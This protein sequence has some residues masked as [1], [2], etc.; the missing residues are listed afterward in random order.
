MSTNTC[1]N[2]NHNNRMFNIK[3]FIYLEIM[4]LYLFKSFEF[5][6]LY[7]YPSLLLNK[8][9]WLFFIFQKQDSL[10]VF[11]MLI[12]Q[13]RKF[14]HWLIFGGKQTRYMCFHSQRRIHIQFCL[15][16]G[17][18]NRPPMWNNT[19]GKLHELWW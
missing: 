11:I 7:K 17:V 19:N 16:I 14:S 12:L 10:S 9:E 1:R 6:Y 5:L 13:L 15:W 8:L 18:Y 4:A 3:V 2:L